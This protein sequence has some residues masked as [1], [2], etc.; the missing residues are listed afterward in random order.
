MSIRQVGPLALSMLIAGSPAATGLQAQ[1]PAPAQPPATFRSTAAVVTV[2]ASVRRRNRPLTGLKA[3]DFEIADN[4]VVQDVSEVTYEKL[5]IDVTV[6]LDVS[7]SVTGPVLDQLRRAVRELK[8]HLGAADR[9]RLLAFDTHVKRLADFDDRRTADAAMDSLG[10]GG[11]SVIFDTL[12]VALTAPADPGRRHLIVLFSDGI[13]SGSISG[14]ETLIEVARRSSPTITVVLSPSAPQSPASAA[15][16][17]PVSTD[18]TV[19]SFYA[20]LASQTGGEVFPTSARESLAATFRRVLDTF[21]SSYV[22]YFTPRGADRA[23]VH[24]LDVRVKQPDV[25][26]R[27]RT[28]YVAP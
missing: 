1:A 21:R 10:G 16:G 6:A 8:A 22:L 19:G 12:A 3:S 2:D 23:G 14:P 5:P 27:A 24:T 20:R 11:G 26:V 9:L 18:M 15:G 17:R 4:G 13:D 7:A 25:D 28:W